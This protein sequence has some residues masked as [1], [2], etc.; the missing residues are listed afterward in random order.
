[1]KY[2]YKFNSTTVLWRSIRAFNLLI[3]INTVQLLVPFLIW[4]CALTGRFPRLQACPDTA[5]RHMVPQTTRGRCFTHPKCTVL[6][7]KK[8]EKH[9]GRIVPTSPSLHGRAF[10]HRKREETHSPFL[11]FATRHVVRLFL[12][13][14]VKVWPSKRKEITELSTGRKTWYRNESDETRSSCASYTY[15]P[16]VLFTNGSSPSALLSGSTIRSQC[17]LALFYQATCLCFFIWSLPVWKYF[18]MDC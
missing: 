1:M 5:T 8:R 15:I 4:L 13:R 17:Y 9:D 16:S 3:F 12:A 7:G 6:L 2:V 10:S 11:M 14:F 18:Q